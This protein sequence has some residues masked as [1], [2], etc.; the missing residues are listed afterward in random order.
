MSLQLVQSRTI[1]EVPV[2]IYDATGRNLEPQQVKHAPQIE[3][4]P[5]T[6]FHDIAT[7]RDPEPLAMSTSVLLDSGCHE[8]KFFIAMQHRDTR[9]ASFPSRTNSA[10]IT[11]AVA[12][13]ASALQIGNQAHEALERLGQI[14]ELIQSSHN[15]PEPQKDMDEL[16]TSAVACR[17]VPLDLE[18]WARRLAGDIEVLTD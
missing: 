16:L 17:G 15:L 10:T 8:S 11:W 14:V 1:A 9:V 3:V 2:S 4:L 12:D 6:M 13:A 5:F 7:D 18:R